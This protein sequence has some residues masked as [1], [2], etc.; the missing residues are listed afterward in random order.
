MGSYSIDIIVIYQYLRG[1]QTP[2]S[3]P[4]SIILSPPFLLHNQI[5]TCHLIEIKEAEM[6]REMSF[7]HGN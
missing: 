4:G 3:P 2:R 1:H 6:A 5:K 7:G